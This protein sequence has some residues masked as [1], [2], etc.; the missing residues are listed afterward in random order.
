MDH[1]YDLAVEQ[2][3][4]DATDEEIAAKAQELLEAAADYAEIVLEDR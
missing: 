1:Y 4:D 3:P 2:L